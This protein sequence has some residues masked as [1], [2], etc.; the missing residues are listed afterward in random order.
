MRLLL[1]D[2]E[3][4]VRERILRQLNWNDLGI[5]D[6]RQASCGVEAV[7]ML[8][9][10]SPDV[11]LTDVRLPNMNG[12][13]LAE[14]VTRANPD[15]KIIFISGYSDVS[16]LRGAIRL[17]AI[18]FVEKPI[19]IQE[20]SDSIRK[21]A[22][23]LRRE[24]FLKSDLD[25]YQS[26]TRQEQ[27]ISAARGLTKSDTVSEAAESVR[28]L[29][30][31]SD[32]TYY[33]SVAL[34]LINT[35]SEPLRGDRQSRDDD[36][37]HGGEPPLYD[38]PSLYD[39]SFAA[40]LNDVFHDNESVAVG[41]VKHD[42][43]AV[44]LFCRSYSFRR[45]EKIEPYLN[46]LI[47][48]LRDLNIKSV[49][50]IGKSGRLPDVFPE[51]YTTAQQALSYCYYNGPGCICHYRDYDLTPYDME[52]IP[53]ANFS[54]ALTKAEPQHFNDMLANLASSIKMRNATPPSQVVRFFSN[55]LG[56]VIR[57]AA[58]ENVKILDA[59]ADEYDVWD[60]IHDLPF[61]DDLCDFTLNTVK[62]YYEQTQHKTN[63]STVNHIIG[64]IKQSYDNPDLS[65]TMISDDIHLTPTYI[66]HLFKD[67]LGT[68][69]GEYITRQ[70]ID[71]AK[72]LLQTGA[73]RV[74]DLARLVGYRNANYFSYAFK[75]ETGYSPG[76][77]QA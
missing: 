3:F 66:C 47:N 26:K 12:L 77:K 25:K 50:A 58:R 9:D 76:V 19:N 8:N 24:H 62:R 63:N 10:C 43:A 49:C 32:F 1:V 59:F 16:A 14:E 61:L 22:S 20:L 17:R 28:Q 69:I 2:D 42:R 34:R 51:S 45:R 33:V 48:R 11:L 38:E 21:A 13:Q 57:A 52:H 37:S 54:Q 41:F 36:Q 6:V 15:C 68:T 40:V 71:K 72:E 44:H 29:S 75:R 18:N 31:S 55:V 56:M 23:D 39:A 27:L 35:P 74:K 65:V 64:F 70:R 46:N 53:L 5:D 4:F 73:Y 30:G 60:Y 7:R 67:T